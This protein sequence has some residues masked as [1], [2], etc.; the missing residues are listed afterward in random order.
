MMTEK[1]QVNNTFLLLH[2]SDIHFREPYCLNL[3]TDQDHAVRQAMLNDIRAMVERLGPVNAILVSGDIA[4]KAHPQEYQIATQWL[5][6]VTHVSGCREVD[7]YTVP[8]N[9]D[10]DRTIAAVRMVQGVRGLISKNPPGPVRDREL[11]DTI[12]DEK[13]GRELLMPMNSYNLFAAPFGCDITPAQPFWVQEFPLGPGWNLKMHGLTTTYL[14]GPDDDV[15][16]QLYLGS[17]QRVFAQS[18]GVVRLVMMHHPPDWFEDNDAIDDALWNS[19]ALHL[20]G[21]KHLQRYRIGTNGVRLAAGAVNPSHTEG[22]WEPGYNFVRLQVIN[23]DDK[24]FL[25]IESYL[26]KWQN[27]PDQFVAKRTEY[28]EEVFIHKVHLRRRASSIPAEKNEEIPNMEGNKK[29]VGP[30]REGIGA[31]GNIDPQRNLVFDFWKLSPSQR[32]KIMQTLALLEPDDDELPEPHR[33]RLG[34]ERAR[35]RGMISKLEDAVSQTL[36]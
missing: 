5:S 8:G 33:Y 20:I 2:L 7:I 28:D 29:E 19:C 36:T 16:G 13:A 1:D 15:R 21:H 34:F 27:S 10:V 32:R 24:Y 3:E 25:K 14:S 9:H 23:E 11:H 30:P 12:L 31:F 26:R 17:H 4:F 22:S 35:E 6:E 18:D